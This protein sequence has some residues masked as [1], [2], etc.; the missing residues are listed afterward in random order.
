MQLPPAIIFINPEMTSS[1]IDNLKNQ[2]FISDQM[3]GVEFDARLAVMPAYPLAVHTQG[4]RILVLRSDLNSASTDGYAD[5][6]M[7]VKNGLVSVLKNNCG[8]PGQTYTMAKLNVYE[9]L[10]AADSSYVKI[11]PKS[12]EPPTVP[13]ILPYGVGVGGIVGEELRYD[14]NKLT[15]VSPDNEYNNTDFIN[16]K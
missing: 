11:L 16:R 10:R 9:L 6:V 14:K 15:Y 3:T 1:Q 13:A 8:P 4:M 5:V 2:L 7:F 12:P